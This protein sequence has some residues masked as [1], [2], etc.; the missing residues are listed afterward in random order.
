MKIGYENTSI[1]SIVIHYK[2]KGNLVLEKNMNLSQF[3]HSLSPL[4]YLTAT[5]GID[6]IDMDIKL[7]NAEIKNVAYLLNFLK[8]VD[9]APKIKHST[10]HWIYDKRSFEIL[11]TGKILQDIVKNKCSFEYEAQLAS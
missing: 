4:Y 5:L 9:A 2:S 1:G 7:T 10:V 3:T 8:E 11:E 6:E